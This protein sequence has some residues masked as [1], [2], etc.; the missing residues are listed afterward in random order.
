MIAPNNKFLLDVEEMYC[1][2]CVYITGHV[3]TGKFWTCCHCGNQQGKKKN[4][5]ESIKDKVNLAI[6]NRRKEKL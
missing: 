4:F 3:L 2:H 5:F 1:N 6:F